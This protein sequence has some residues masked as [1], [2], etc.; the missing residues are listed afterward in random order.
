MSMLAEPRKKYKWVANPRGMDW[1]SDDNKFGQKLMEKMGWSKGKGLGREEQGDVDHVAVHVKN[2]TRGIGYKVSDDQWIQHYEGFENVL[3]GLNKQNDNANSPNDTSAA[4]IACEKNTQRT[5]LECLSKNSQ[6]RVHYHKFTRGKDLTRLNADDIGCITGSKQAK[7]I[8]VAKKDEHFQEEEIGHKQHS[9]GITTINGGSY[10]DYFAKKLASIRGQLGPN[11]EDNKTPLD[12]CEATECTLNDTEELSSVL[13]KTSKKKRKHC[14][15]KEEQMK[16]YFAGETDVI[17][18]NSVSS[19]STGTKSCY[20]MPTISKKQKKKGTMLIENKGHLNK[21]LETAEGF[22]LE[23]TFV[24]DDSFEN[25][26]PSKTEKKSK[27]KVKSTEI[28]EYNC[29]KQLQKIKRKKDR[30]LED[31]L[32]NEEKSF[33]KIQGCDLEKKKIQIKLKQKYP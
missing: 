14:S 30:K 17:A 32:K 24:D 31:R 9:S 20:M 15:E 12:T 25:L 28:N 21:Y 2:N 10:Q 7:K 33:K 26:R 5:S 13:S 16:E 3:A 19:E 8:A 6:A 18:G 1:V 4:N 27:K 29:K 11:Q 22:E 23:N